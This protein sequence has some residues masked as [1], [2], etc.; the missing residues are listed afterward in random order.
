MLP[1]VRSVCENPT[2]G[3]VLVGTRGGEIVEFGGPK[4][5][6]LMRSHFEGE[7]WGLVTHPVRQEFVTVGNDC[8]L[9]IW[10]IKTRKQK[11]FGKLEQAANVLAFSTSGV[12]LA[13]GYN[14]GAFHVLEPDNKFTLKANIKNRKEAISDMKFNP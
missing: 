6:I 9:G 11:R 8:V 14:N 7:L 12:M 3:Q 10:D 5:L 2:T 4:P 13:I 1:K